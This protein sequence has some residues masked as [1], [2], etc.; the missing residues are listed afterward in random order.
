MAKHDAVVTGTGNPA[1][2]V[3]AIQAAVDR[4]GSIL[5]K[6]TFDFGTD[7]HV[8]LKTDVKIRGEEGGGVP[9][10]WIKGGFVPFAGGY[11]PQEFDDRNPTAE[12]ISIERWPA[13]FIIEDIGFENPKWAAILIGATTGTMIRG[14]HIIGGRPMNFDQTQPI[15]HAFS[16]GIVVADGSVYW[17][18]LTRHYHYGRNIIS[19]DMIVTISPD[20][21]HFRWKECEKT[22]K[23][24]LYLSPDPEKPVIVGVGDEPESSVLNICID[25]FKPSNTVKIDIYKYDALSAFLRHA[26]YVL[27]K[28]TEFI[29]P[30][31]IIRGTGSLEN[32]LSGYQYMILKEAF[33]DAGAREV[34]F[35]D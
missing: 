17:P 13:S 15:D 8:I 22:L 31:V 9:R 33:I 35:D 30:R 34:V 23:T 5:L 2:D 21:F 6:G 4:G 11:D 12:G 18:Y 14:C 10:T 26:F 32:I 20:N 24:R 27:L 19:G 29:R 1:C 3:A 16:S 7:G 28:K 25:L